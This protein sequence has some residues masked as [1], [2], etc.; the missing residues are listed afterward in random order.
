MYPDAKLLV[1]VN[2]P[3]HVAGMQAVGV[4]EHILYTLAK[5]RDQYLIVAEKRLGELQLRTGSPFKKLL[6]F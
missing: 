4:N 5:W 1:F 6:S 3:W 2:E